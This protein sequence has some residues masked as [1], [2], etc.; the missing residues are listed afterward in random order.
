MYRLTFASKEFP[1][2]LF[3]PCL[4]FSNFLFTSFLSFIICCHFSSSSGFK[5]SSLFTYQSAK[6]IDSDSLVSAGKLSHISSAVK[7]SIGEPFL[8]KSLKLH[9]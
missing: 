7:E 3:S 1:I 9:T 6:K 5:Y 8:L 4:A 2:I